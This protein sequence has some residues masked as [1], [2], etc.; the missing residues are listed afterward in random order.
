M[1]V[2]NNAIVTSPLYVRGNMCMANNS[3]FT[4]SQLQVKGTLTVN[5]GAS[6]GYSA[7]PIATAKLQ[8]GCMS[9][10]HVCTSGDSV[11]AT[12]LTS[13][14]DN[15]TKPSVDMAGSYQNARP[16]PKHDC[17]TGSITGGF[18]TDTTYNNSR[19]LFDLT[20]AIELQLRRRIGATTVG[21]LSWNATTHVLTIAGTIFFDGSVQVSGTA[22]YQGL[23][24]IYSAGKITLLEQRPPLRRLRL[25]RHLGSREQPRGDCGRR[26]YRHRVAD[27][28]T[29]PSIRA[30][31]TSSPTTSW[32]TTPRTGVP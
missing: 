15:I 1:D 28:T 19:A 13:T 21:Q 5:N 23:G 27:Q 18:D 30:P 10:P 8:G 2:S 22:T 16:G 31:P 14:A 7:T 20:P 3:H 9:G 6:V 4:G 17:T 29:T 25:R 32:R 24:T 11:Y 26:L 12:S